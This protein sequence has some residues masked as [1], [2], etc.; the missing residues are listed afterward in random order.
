[1]RIKTALEDFV[2]TTLA[3]VP[4]YWQKLLYLGGL[5]QTTAEYDHWGLKRRYGKAASLTAME[6]AHTNVF[7]EILRAPLATL[8]ADLRT[9]AR[10]Q[11]RSEKEYLE[12]LNQQRAS[13]VPANDGGGSASHFEVTVL[14]LESL[15]QAEAEADRPAE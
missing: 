15:T 13:I 7:L 10:Q 8:L 14:A 12:M 1:M 3:A 4:G 9:S 11:E 6:K 5:R 2:K